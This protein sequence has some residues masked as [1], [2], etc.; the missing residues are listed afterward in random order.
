M[1]DPDRVGRLDLADI[2]R[3]HR[4]ELEAVHRLTRSHKRVL[5]DIPNCRTA[6]LGGHL[7]RCQSC[8]YEHPSY[9]SCRNRH[10]PKSQALIQ[11][12]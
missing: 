5:T 8:G 2:V 11:E 12:K 10:C 6:V 3:A 7:D 4:A 1:P 9:N